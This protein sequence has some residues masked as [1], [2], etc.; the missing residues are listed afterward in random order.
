MTKKPSEL[1]ILFLSEEYPPETGWGGI[2][3]STH[4]TAHALAH[5]G[6]DVHVLSAVRSQRERHYKDDDV[7]VH[8][9]DVRDLF[10]VGRR[11]WAAVSAR[12]LERALATYL[13]SQRLGIQFDVVEYPECGAEGLFFSLRRKWATVATLHT[14]WPLLVEQSGHEGGVSDR[15]AAYLEGLSVRRADM[16]TSPSQAMA[17]W[18]RE[19]F[20]L[21]SRPVSIVPHPAPIHAKT[22]SRE[23]VETLREGKVVFV[24]R[25]EFNKNP[26]VIVRAAKTV[27]QKVLGAEFTFAGGAK[28]RDGVDYQ[29]WLT[30]LADAYG[31]AGRVH[32]AGHLE[33]QDVDAL[34]RSAS[35]LVVPSRWE[36]FPYV[37]L[38]AMTAARPIVASRVGGIPEMIRDGETGLLVDPEDTEG[39]AQ[40]I[41]ALL[42][43]HEQ[44]RQMGLRAQ[45][46]ALDRFDPD[47]IAAQR[48][49]IYRE[50]IRL[51]G[52]QRKRQQ[53]DSSCL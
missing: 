1:R 33:R 37:L 8:R 18:T 26:D 53:S 17:D 4:S 48:E 46:D 40:A 32:F 45:V 24:G 39:W 20:R 28:L 50:A 10:R 14:S 34:Q 22:A 13:A 12:H 2:A 47:K 29:E 25:L 21:R 7:Y 49:A 36:N 9:S 43:D 11:R 35:V 31:V 51:H 3:R 27:C 42:T 15:V 16:I 23:F 5:R 52:T 30:R 44:A 6:H 41:I 38:E 19:T